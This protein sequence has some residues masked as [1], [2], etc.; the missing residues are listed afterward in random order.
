MLKGPVL[1][2]SGYST[3]EVSFS[4]IIYS[5]T[6]RHGG[7]VRIVLKLGKSK[8]AICGPEGLFLGGFGCFG[9]DSIIKFFLEVGPD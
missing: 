4:T 3:D 8:A 6:V 2:D 7:I 9:C 5:K 1:V